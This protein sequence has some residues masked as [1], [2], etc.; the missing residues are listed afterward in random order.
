MAFTS[1]IYTK[2]ILHEKKLREIKILQKTKHNQNI[3]KPYV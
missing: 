3:Q 1:S 2:S